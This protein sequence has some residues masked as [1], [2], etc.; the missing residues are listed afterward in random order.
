MSE[1]KSSP[2]ET[3]EQEHADDQAGVTL[4]K[5]SQPEEGQSQESPAAASQASPQPAASAPPTSSAPAAAD[6]KEEDAS[7]AG[8][9]ELH[10]R[11]VDPNAQA[12]AAPPRESG[13][14]A[15]EFVDAGATTQD[16]A[17]LFEAQGDVPQR[18]EIA[19]GDKLTA[20]VTHIDAH[21]VFVDLGGKGE[22]RASRAQY[23]DPEGNLQVEVGQEIEFFI[24]RFTSQGVE[25]GKQLDTRQSGV[26]ALEEA[27]ASGLPVQGKVKSKNKGGFVIDIA[28]TEAFCP[29]SQI[30]LRNAEDLDV[31]LNQTFPFRVTEVREGGKNI[32]VSRAALLREQERERRAEVMGRIKVGE[33]LKGAV[34]SISDFG[35]FVDLGGIDGLVHVSEMSW[36]NVGKPSDV[37]KEGQMV[38]VKILEIEDRK[39]KRGPRISLSMKQVQEDPWS[40]VAQSF[41]EGQQVEGKVVRVAQFGAFVE[42]QPGVDGLVHVS[43]MSWE[44]VKR[45]SDVVSLGDVVAAQ[46]LTIDPNRQRISLSMKAVAGDPWSDI[47]SAYAV[48]QEVQ[49]VVEKIEDFGVFVSLGQ[50]ITALLPR[51][52]MDL[53]GDQTPHTRLR[54]GQDVTTKVLRI[55]PDKRRMAL[56]LRD[57]ISQST[58]SRGGYDGGGND[59]GG[60]DRGGN[61]RGSR[62]QGNS[63]SRRPRRDRDDGPT[64]YNDAP[65][66]ESFGSLGDLLDLKKK[67]EGK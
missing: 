60:N 49:G 27:Q 55:E 56:S 28:G 24:L 7:A 37:V 62:N 18:R 3:R 2:S 63:G 38:E 26:A 51:S 45:P 34:R 66:A 23:S 25:I 39:G 40:T 31:Y 9:P 6:S 33:T 42:L 59:R 35:A 41:Y 58:D 43:E 22:A 67:L 57:D 47:E 14:K 48:G 10:R 64:H 46:I 29:L 4:R 13:A 12:P 32:V 65:P 1:H 36:G 5:K 16:F 21:Y 20:P 19:V 54:Q 50:G 61:D 30:D 17:A 44:H 15:V 52:E 8:A 53:A 11:V